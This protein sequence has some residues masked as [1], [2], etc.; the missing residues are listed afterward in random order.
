MESTFILQQGLKKDHAATLLYA[1]DPANFDYLFGD[2]AL[3]V[4]QHMWASSTGFLS[5]K[6]AQVLREEDGLVGIMFACHA[7]EKAA[8]EAEWN[9][10]LKKLN[11]FTLE[12]LL[13]KQ[14]DLYNLFPV[15]PENAWY[16]NLLA[17]APHRRGQG[18]GKRFLS[19]LFEQVKNGGNTMLC[20]DVDTA[21]QGAINFYR[22][23]GFIAEVKTEVMRLLAH[24]LPASLRME[25]TLI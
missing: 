15:V 6:Y 17:I 8:R 20:V 25:K 5:H 14:H 12:T 19:V 4:L 24:R 13:S 2:T 3:T 22:N 9:A 11:G 18:L 1:S 16:L 23:A 7:V 21:N 10:E